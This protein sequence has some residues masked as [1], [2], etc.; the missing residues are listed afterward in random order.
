MDDHPNPASVVWDSKGLSIKADNS[1]LQQ[2]LLDVETATGTKIEGVGPDERVF[3][4][5]GPGLARDVLSQLLHGFSYNVLMIGDLGEGAPRSIILTPRT[6]ASSQ[7]KA[8]LSEASTSDD[9]AADAESEQQL[10][11]GPVPKPI[12]PGF[13]PGGAPRTPQQIMQRLMQQQQQMVN[14]GAPEPQ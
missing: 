3:G 6:P 5:Y 1:S 4:V 7:T 12:R 10:Q 13:V 9:G 8:S 14:Q 11:Q 2:I